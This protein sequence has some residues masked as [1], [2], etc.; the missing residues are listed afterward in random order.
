MAQIVCHADTSTEMVSSNAVQTRKVNRRD[1]SQ[2][3][4]FASPLIYKEPGQG[5]LV[6]GNLR[7]A[8][9]I[10]DGSQPKLLIVDVVCIM[11]APIQMNIQ[12]L[13]TEPYAAT[14]QNPQSEQ[15]Q[16][17]MVKWQD[18]LYEGRHA[19]LI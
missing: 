16:L 14:C 19:H 6:S 4:M 15:Q 8:S 18:M 7:A 10:C 17:G 1:Y 11:A 12:E 9:A 13:P 5:E 2:H 3:Q